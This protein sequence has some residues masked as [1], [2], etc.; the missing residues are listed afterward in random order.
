MSRI[1]I[2]DI[3]NNGTSNTD[4][5]VSIQQ[6]T[7][8]PGNGYFTD[9][10]TSG[11]SYGDFDQSY[12]AING[13]TYG[14]SPSTYTVQA[15]DTLQSIAQAIWGDSSFWY[16]LAD[17][18]GLDGSSQLDAGVTL[19]VPNDIANNQNNTGTYRV[20]D[21]NTH[22]GYTQKLRSRSDRQSGTRAMGA[23]LSSG[24][25]AMRLRQKTRPV[26]RRSAP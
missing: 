26:Q 19:I 23:A 22:I 12:D 2:G 13:Q 18:N 7:T 5:V 11:I 16:L 1:Q 9:G 10:A 3:S 8:K 6:Q 4:Y 24:T 15:G 14:Q 17:A 25:A 20:Y 21:P